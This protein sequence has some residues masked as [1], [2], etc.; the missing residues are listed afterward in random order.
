MVELAHTLGYL[1]HN[2][3]L[4]RQVDDVSGLVMDLAASIR[5]KL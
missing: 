2:E 1:E 5:R 3:E 4:Q